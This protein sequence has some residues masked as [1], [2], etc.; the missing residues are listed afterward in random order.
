M[1]ARR[2]WWIALFVS[3]AVFV[4]IAL[5]LRGDGVLPFDVPLMWWL[6]GL[7]SERL[8]GLAWLLARLGYG[9]GLPPLYVAL[10]AGLAHRRLGREALFVVLA[11]GGSALLNTALKHLF[12]RPRPMLW[13]TS[14]VQYSFSFPSGHATAC[15]T[16]A[17]VLVALTWRTRWRWPVLLAGTTFAVVVGTSRVYLGVHFPSDVVAGWATG[18]AWVSAMHLWLLARRAPGI[19]PT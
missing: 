17:C 5:A 6:H 10:V 14:E 13:Q 19:P 1:R 18:M 3:G 15:A 11:A 8:D 2:R 16:L 7:A 12:E 9:Y 4:A